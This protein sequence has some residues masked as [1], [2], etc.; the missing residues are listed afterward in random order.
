MNNRNTQ[1]GTA[2][3]QSD[4]DQLR[5]NLGLNN[6][7]D[8]VMNDFTTSIQENA[9]SYC[10]SVRSGDLVDTQCI[11]NYTEF[12]ATATY[13]THCN[14][15]GGRNYA[16]SVLV[17]CDKFDGNYTLDM[18]LLNV[19]SCIGVS[20]DAGYLYLTLTHILDGVKES[21]GDGE[22]TDNPDVDAWDCTYYHSMGTLADAPATV[23]TMEGNDK[24]KSAGS[25]IRPMN[26][27]F[28]GVLATTAAMLV[29]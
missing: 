3:C 10:T 21:M 5:T 8:A 15:L 4:T 16:T 26:S 7:Y 6:A 17:R 18:Q 20:C 23:I 22:G 29:L 12:D 13:N 28:I 24:K 11:S 25:R 27:I 9:A 2:A 14:T 1:I 19:P